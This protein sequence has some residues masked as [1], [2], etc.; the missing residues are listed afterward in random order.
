MSN[1]AKVGLIILCV[2]AAIGLLYGVA[3]LACSLSCGGSEGAATLVM[4]G[5]VGVIAF[6]L[7]IAIRAIT[8]KNN[9]PK[10]T[11]P[12]PAEPAKTDKKE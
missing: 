12:D 4:I 5:G 3:A 8:K 1:G 7:V 11:E 6:L 2:L 10:K 9:K